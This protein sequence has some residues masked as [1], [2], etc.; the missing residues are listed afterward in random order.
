M[1]LSLL[2]VL[3]WVAFI[4]LAV[5]L[6]YNKIRDLTIGI[7]APTVL[8]LFF[9]LLDRGLFSFGITKAIGSAIELAFPAVEKF[10]VTSEGLKTDL[11]VTVVLLIFLLVW[12]AN[13]AAVASTT[14]GSAPW[15]KSKTRPVI[16]LLCAF[17][18][19][20]VSSFLVSFAIAGSRNIYYIQIGFLDKLYELL[21]PWEVCF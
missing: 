21:F 20:S 15:Q 13:A 8:L 17:L 6:P 19:L 5:F 9:F 3:L 4:F 10:Q 14:T 7:L 18:F 16:H 11:G 12:G 1:T 2:N